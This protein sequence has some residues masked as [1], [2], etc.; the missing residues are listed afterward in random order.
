MPRPWI[1][2]PHEPVRTLEEN[3]MDVRGEVPGG[4]PI[5]RRMTVARRRDGKLVIFNA[6]PLEEPAM[7]AL[8]AFGEPAF[9]IV[10]NGYHRIDAHP[11]SARYPELRVL[12]PSGAHARILERVERVEPLS[13]LDGDPD[14]SAQEVP[15]TGGREAMMRVQSGGRVSLVFADT[16]FNLPHLPGLKGLLVRLVGSSGG[17]RVTPIFKRLAVKDPESFRQGLL[18]LADTPGLARLIVS[19]GEMV[20]ENAAATLRALALRGRAP[21]L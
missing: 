1:V 17:P 11:F 14:V 3:L 16:F 2:A 7:K 12:G 6:V 4:V 15:G 10:P 5:G 20:Q 18:A 8:E 19:H 21:A 9:L 13:V